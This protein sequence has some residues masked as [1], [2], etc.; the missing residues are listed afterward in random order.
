[1]R[2]LLNL[3]LLLLTGTGMVTQAAGPVTSI[4]EG[5]PAHLLN[6]VSPGKLNTGRGK[7]AALQKGE[8][9]SG[10]VPTADPEEADL[11]LGPFDQL[12]GP[13][14]D[15]LLKAKCLN[16]PYTVPPGRIDQKSLYDDY[17][18][19]FD[20]GFANKMG[21]PLQSKSLLNNHVTNNRFPGMFLRMCFHDNSV[22]P[23]HGSFNEYVKKN[24]NPQG[25]WIGPHHYMETS[26]ADASVLL[27]PQEMYHPNHRTMTRRHRGS[28]ML[29]RVVKLALQMISQVLK[30]T[31]STST[32]YRIPICCRTEVSRPPFISTNKL[33]TCGLLMEIGSRLVVMTRV[34]CLQAWSITEMQIPVKGSGFVG[35]LNFCRE[36]I[37][38]QTS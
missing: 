12:N 17:V 38:I 37:W 2:F 6:E 8:R 29:Y 15:P 26:G 28:S 34:M 24:L 25:K 20:W 30:Q 7:E 13:F 33:L 22:N 27:C 11:N 32:V 35:Q 5:D 4:N 19:I 23:E 1:M 18:K 3:A 16:E 21:A 31:W 36:Y 9:M 10:K 14:R